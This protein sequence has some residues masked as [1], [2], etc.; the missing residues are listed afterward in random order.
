M[1]VEPSPATV[2][3]AGL[4]EDAAAIHSLLLR[5]NLCAPAVDDLERATHARIGEITSCVVEKGG[6]VFGVLQWCNL[7]EEVE[8]LDLAVDPDCRRQGHAA[9]LLRNFLRCTAESAGKKIFLEVRESNAAAIALYQKFGFE[10]SGRR[11]HYYRNPEEDALL[12]V[13]ATK[14]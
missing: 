10:I 11:P 1:K 14:A 4:P 13:L 12:M 2:F 7:G 6:Q 3:R 9:F 8:I 5:S